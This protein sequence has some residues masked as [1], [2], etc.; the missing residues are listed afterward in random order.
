MRRRLRTAGA[1]L[2]VLAAC[3]PR[4]P[5]PI[6]YGQEACGYCRMT[7]SDQRFG[8][9]LLT[10]KGKRYA[11][12]SI[13]C[14]ASF[15]LAQKEVPRGV[16]VSDYNR[17]GTLVAADSAEFRRLSRATGSP[18][19]KGLV[20]TRRGDTASSDTAAAGAMGW[21]DVLALV[22]A[23]GMVGEANHAH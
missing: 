9:E 13:E 20:A 12:D 22:R 7:I 1:V 16:W 5:R 10:A 4:A 21:T 15:A 3:A 8:A 11:F 18:M 2:L 6:A 17:P 14:L 19:G 23:D